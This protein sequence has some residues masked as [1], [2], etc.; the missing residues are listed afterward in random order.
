MVSWQQMRNFWVHV[1]FEH[2]QNTGKN[3]KSYLNNFVNAENKRGFS[4]TVTQLYDELFQVCIT[5]DQYLSVKHGLEQRIKMELP[6]V[7]GRG[8]FSGGAREQKSFKSAHEIRTYCENGL[9]QLNKPIIKRKHEE[10]QDHFI[11]VRNAFSIQDEK[12]F[13][14]FDIEAY[15]HDHSQVL[16]IGYVIVRFSPVRHRTEGNLPKAEVT[17]REHLIIEENLHFK[18]KDNVPDNRDGF[19]FGVSET[20]SL[21][22]AVE[23]FFICKGRF[24]LHN[25]CLKLSHV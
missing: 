5:T 22:D 23:R 20:L 15:E 25:F 21:E 18:N 10:A 16:E 3:V 8:L 12:D 6:E 17:S 9:V 1:A 4:F 24:K 2:S 13:L 7:R 11:E 14:A 19:K